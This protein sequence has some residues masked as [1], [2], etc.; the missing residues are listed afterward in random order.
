MGETAPRPFPLL[1][2]SLEA[3]TVLE[4]TPKRSVPTNESRSYHAGVASCQACGFDN[5]DEARFCGR[6]GESLAGT[7]PSCGAPV[8]QGTAFCTACGSPLHLDTRPP[9]GEERKVVTVLFVDLVGFTARAERLDPED[10]RAILSRYYERVKA[11]IERFGGQVEKFVGDAVMG[12]F[13]APVAYGDD[14]ERA[15]RAA[16]AVRDQLQEMNQED[17]SLDL[18]A[19][20]AVNTGEAI[21]ALGAHPKRGEG[22]VAGDVV[23]TASRLQSAAPTGGILVG[24]ETYFSTRAVIEYQA[25]EPVDAKG[26]ALPVTAWLAVAPLAPVGERSFS[27]VPMVGRGTELAVVRG[28][29][30]RVVEESRPHL[31]TIFGP[32]GIGKSRLAHEFSLRVDATG[33]RALRGRS[34]AY[35]ESSPYGAF[36]QIVKQLVGIFDN[37]ELSRSY[38][39]L[40]AAVSELV[41]TAETDEA[42]HHIAILVGLRTE[43]SVSDRETLFFSA[44]LLVEGLAAQEP[45]VLIFEDIHWADPSLLDLI[46]S[47]A[48]RVRDVPLLL[49]T[50]ARPE[51]LS[52]RQ[53]WGGGLPAYT[54]LPLEP[55]AAS[56]AV[57]LTRRFLAQHA[58][59]QSGEQAEL[60]ATTA[61]GNPLFIEEL[62]A[63]IAER[64]A[65]DAQELPTS[66]RGI[67]SARLDALPPAE[68]SVLRDASVVGR[69]FWNGALTRLSREGEDLPGVLGSLENRDLIRRARVSRIRGEQ[70]FV[71][72]HVLIRDVA[73]QSL[74]RSERRQRHAAVARF[75]EEATPDL[76][77]AAAALALHWREAG[78][79]ER[80]LTYLVAAAE[81]AGRGWAK[82][83]ALRL[84]QEALELV[85]ERNRDLRRDIL[86]RLAIASQAT[87]HVF[88]AERL[89]ARSEEGR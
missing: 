31:A 58:V 56:D 57:E 63:S 30:E 76:G 52:R 71:F 32:T 75:L 86:R 67:I 49:L 48:G 62:S 70:Q 8:T 59:A 6:C 38:E 19:R 84:Y 83:S 14:P 61:E 24:E 46:E 15:V 78:E 40:R 16:L 51:L 79:P 10:V 47:L 53:S 65:T 85:P 64:P 73:Y 25:A 41:G 42:S 20:L 11:E 60:L 22:M 21:V 82:E 54:A 9:S 18:Q 34:V 23:N 37:D 55:L 3:H 89:R 1:G 68:R 29:W 33:G 12:V 45:T 26:K 7:C 13:G 72:K 2:G 36:A 74:P 69:V 5:P 50:L 35:G 88:D 77:D 81:Q 43:G 17:P 4:P 28:I 87:W 66:I 27:G 39:K 44:R 80:A